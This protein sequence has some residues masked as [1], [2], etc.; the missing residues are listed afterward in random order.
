MSLE[1]LIEYSLLVCVLSA[2]AG[3]PAL[4]SGGCGDVCS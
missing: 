2:E 3:A 1:V 4:S